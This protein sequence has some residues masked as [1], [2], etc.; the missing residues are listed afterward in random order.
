[1][2]SDAIRG[3]HDELYSIHG[4]GEKS[5][6]FRLSDCKAARAALAKEKP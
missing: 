6:A 2:G 3:L 1:M 5:A 4:T